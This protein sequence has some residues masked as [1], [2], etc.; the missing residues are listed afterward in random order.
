MYERGHT[1]HLRP[2]KW[3]SPADI[4]KYGIPSGHIPNRHSFLKPSITCVPCSVSK[5][6]RQ[7]LH[8]HWMI[9]KKESPAKLRGFLFVLVALFLGMKSN[10]PLN[11]STLRSDAFLSHWY[12]YT[13]KAKIILR[14]QSRCFL[15]VY[16]R[17]V[18]NIG[19]IVHNFDAELHNAD[20]IKTITN[21]DPLISIGCQ[22]LIVMLLLQ[23]VHNQTISSRRCATA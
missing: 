6:Y 15:E 7:P 19:C 17:L 12:V 10:V 16:S 13:F 9:N 8:S 5:S 22:T 20:T 21:N 23:E 3:S 1:N 2:R 11:R 18:P 14:T 4:R